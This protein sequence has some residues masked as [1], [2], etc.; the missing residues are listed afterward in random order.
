MA[1]RAI[2]KK[3][4]ERLYSAAWAAKGYELCKVYALL[5]YGGFRISETLQ[6]SPA[7]IIEGCG[8]GVMLAHIPKQN[9]TREVPLSESAAS[10][11][12]GLCHYSASLFHFIK[13]VCVDHL[14]AKVN[15]HIESVLGEGFSSHGFRRGYISDMLGADS[16][17]IGAKEVAAVV[18]HKSLKTTAIYYEVPL[19]AKIRR[20]QG[21]R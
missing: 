17:D 13:P 12:S 9:I 2:R 19:E 4:F 8:C 6:F 16:S 10:L 5:Y 15:A 18:G 14:T 11:L 3:E 1:S 21:V 7:K 20:V